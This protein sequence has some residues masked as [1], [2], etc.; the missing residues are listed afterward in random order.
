[1]YHAPCDLSSLKLSRNS[2]H[3]LQLS[4]IGV[5]NEESNRRMLREMLFTA[6]DVEQ[7]I[8]GVVSMAN[9]T[10]ALL[11]TLLFSTGCSHTAA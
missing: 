6:P 2:T 7:Y 5:A 3:L 9:G 8:S 1:M 4:S 10:F 11:Y